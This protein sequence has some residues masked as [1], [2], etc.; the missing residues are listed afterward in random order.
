MSLLTSLFGRN[1]SK[2]KAT[3][4]LRPAQIKM[5]YDAEKDM[6]HSVKW[7][8]VDE[9]ELGPNPSEEVKLDV[10]KSR[11][12]TFF[13][14]SSF[15]LL[16]SQSDLLLENL[17]G[18][19]IRILKTLNWLATIK[20]NIMNKHYF[21]PDLLGYNSKARIYYSRGLCQE[22]KNDTKDAYIKATA[23][24]Y[25][26]ILKPAITALDEEKNR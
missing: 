2:S 22:P 20:Q 8:F 10:M 13:E 5:F 14:K 23:D 25:V 15:G 21:R 16:I 17:K 9:S 18:A 26:N 11:I 19:D 3:N 12:N 1:S 4:V 7:L 6:V 24:Y